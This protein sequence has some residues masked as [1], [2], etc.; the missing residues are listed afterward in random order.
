MLCV[1]Q[2]DTCCRRRGCGEQASLEAHGV[3]LC[4]RERGDR[5]VSIAAPHRQSASV[6][7]GLATRVCDR[8]A[9]P[10]FP[11]LNPRKRVRGSLRKRSADCRWQGSCAACTL[12]KAADLGEV[13]AGSQLL[14]GGLPSLN[15]GTGSC[16]GG[17]RGVFPFTQRHGLLA[18]PRAC[19]PKDVQRWHTRK[20]SPA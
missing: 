16:P 1:V 12:H 4:P 6:R 2:T 5:G 18:N 9:S 11:T 17:R 13:R 7:T 10:A 14:A 19:R 3:I 8:P 15:P 20:S